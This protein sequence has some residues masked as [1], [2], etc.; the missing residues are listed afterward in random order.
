MILRAQISRVIDKYHYSVRIPQFNKIHKAIGAT[1]ESELYVATAAVEAGISP[2]FKTGD[3]VLVAFE[4]GSEDAPT[5][6]GLLFNDKAKKS[7]SDAAFT[8]LDV[9]ANAKFGPD[10]TIGNVTKDNIKH[11]EKLDVNIKEKFTL[12]DKAIDANKTAIKKIITKTDKLRKDVDLNTDN[13][14]TNAD[15][16]E[17]NKDDIKDLNTDLSNHKKDTTSHITAA[18]RKAWNSKAAGNHT[19]TSFGKMVLT[20]DKTYGDTLPTSAE[21]GQLFFLTS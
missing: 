6:I 1:P 2:I 12:I 19:H 11:L 20:K 3:V 9:S 8:S 4:N 21:E 7:K 13:I 17:K 18:D 16:I 14:K 5:V 15:N 10:V